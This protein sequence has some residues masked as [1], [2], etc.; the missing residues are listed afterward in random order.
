VWRRAIR[1][2][3]EE[4]RRCRWRRRDSDRGGGSST[5]IVGFSLVELWL[6]LCGSM[7]LHSA[8]EVGPGLSNVFSKVDKVVAMRNGIR[9]QRSQRDD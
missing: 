1:S 6:R 8:V 4:K 5:A 9:S 7:T 2:I 3:S